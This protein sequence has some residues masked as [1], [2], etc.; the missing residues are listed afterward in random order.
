[1]P[2]WPVNCNSKAV[3]HTAG[4]Q[5]TRAGLV[6]SGDLPL[7]F[8][9]QLCELFRLIGRPEDMGRV[10]R[11]HQDCQILVGLGLCATLHLRHNG[12]DVDLHA[13]GRSGGHTY[14]CRHASG[15]HAAGQ[16][17]L[18]SLQAPVKVKCS[19]NLEKGQSL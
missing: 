17:V 3:D 2:A 1:M 19:G 14:S 9:L 7:K 11:G 12:Q 4:L 10:I 6:C 8:Y 13:L 15:H 5:I 18:P 16:Q